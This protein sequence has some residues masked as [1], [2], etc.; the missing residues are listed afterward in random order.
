MP[1][2]QYKA[3]SASGEVVEGEL[4][5]KDR[6][7]AVERLRREGNVPIR[8]EERRGAG[9]AAGQ[10]RV[11]RRTGA[12]K[13]PGKQVGFL[14]REL[15][16]LLGAGL[17][18]D[19]SL[20]ILASLSDNAA[21]RGVVERILERVRSGKSLADGLDAEGSVF[22]SYYAGMVRAGE[23][24]GTLEAVLER[25]AET[26]ERSAALKDEVVTA[27]LYPLLVVV[28]AIVSLTLLITVVIP[29]L[30][31]LFEESGSEISLVTSAVLGF[32]DLARTL[33]W[34]PI[35]VILGLILGLRQMLS[36]E[37]GRA[38]LDAFV[39]GLPLVGDLVVKLEAARLS[40]TL[41]TLLA[42]GVS[43]LNAVS[44]AVGAIGNR[45]VAAE[46][47][48]VRGRLAK[49][50]GLARPLAD[51]DL[52]PDLAV[53]LIEIGEESGRLEAMLLQVADIYDAEV[54]RTINRMLALLVPAITIALGLVIVVLIG[55]VLQALLS[56]YELPL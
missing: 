25:L 6:A 13:I 56:A 39:L 47:S 37:A 38:R 17:T 10:R 32:S 28:V 54:K 7:A 1:R 42:N 46:V 49:G 30:R 20:S 21:L 44:M 48:E 40:R 24:G 4:E 27:L 22:P 2:F 55:S 12:G 18:L 41:G 5:A 43:A 45:A 9:A 51:L 11:E 35:I 53:R 15:S 19:R 33:W 23:A 29:E 31:P 3:V 8:A 34:L 50:E 26:M 16:V 14:T 52:F 36:D